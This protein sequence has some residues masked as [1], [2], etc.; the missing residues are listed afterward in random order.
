MTVSTQPYYTHPHTP[1]HAYPVSAP[2]HRLTFDP[3]CPPSS[4]PVP[5]PAYTMRR[6]RSVTPSLPNRVTH[7]RRPST[8]NEV[9][10]S[11][12]ASSASTASAPTWRHHPGHYGASTRGYH[13]YAA[14]GHA[15]DHAYRTESV[16]THSSPG[17][18]P[19]AVSLNTDYTHESSHH[20]YAASQ[21]PS[22]H[23]L[24]HEYADPQ[25]S[26]HLQAQFAHMVSLNGAPSPVEG[27]ELTYPH[28]ETYD[29]G[30]GSVSGSGPGCAYGNSPESPV[31]EQH[32]SEY[33]YAHSGAD[34][35]STPPSPADGAMYRLDHVVHSHDPQLH[36][37]YYEQQV[38]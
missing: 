31:V 24:A 20:E 30:S 4:A 36:Q 34:Y 37:Q 21:Q 29:E 32:P 15:P 9:P 22:P 25:P 17:A 33:Q 35:A 10:S 19:F 11:F 28:E 12:G 16:S 27:L 7:A 6:P 2:S 26:P 3:I 38:V 1:D 18:S 13:P 8:A 5:A 23:T 14:P